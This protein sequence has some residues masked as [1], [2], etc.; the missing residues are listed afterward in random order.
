[1]SEDA[2]VTQ[3]APQTEAAQVETPEP[4]LEDVYKEAG[5]SAQPVTEQPRQPEAPRQPA[6]TQ[7]PEI[8]VPDPYDT[9]AHKAFMATQA[10]ELTAL[11]QGFTQLAQ[12][13][14]TQARADAERAMRADVSKAVETMKQA[15]PDLDE[16]VLEA[17]LDGQARKDP[18][19]QT[20]W[21]NRAKNPEAWEKAVKAVSRDLAGKVSVK[22][23]PK[24][25][26]AQQA[27]KIAQGA[28]ATTAASS[29]DDKWD[30]MKQEDFASNWERM[31]NGNSA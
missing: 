9:P 26:A 30:G 2:G 18:R 13:L 22:V 23:D 25:Q 20:L 5:S 17:F 4:S 8:V 12:H 11:K 16:P 24:L 10:N 21:N 1:M 31:V 15:V 29:P 14:G 6:V 7:P 28:M 3:E 27:R 19:F